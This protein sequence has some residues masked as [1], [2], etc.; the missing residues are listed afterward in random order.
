MKQKSLL[1]LL[2]ILILFSGCIIITGCSNKSSGSSA[3]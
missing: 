1:L 3:K 2:P